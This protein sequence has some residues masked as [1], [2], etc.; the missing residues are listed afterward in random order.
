MHRTRSFIFSSCLLL[1]FLACSHTP[2]AIN[3]DNSILQMRQDYL[4]AHPGGEYN[5]YI[6]RGEVVRGMN[7][8]EVSA[9]WGIPETRRMSKDQTLEYWTFYE[10]D[11]MSGDWM[12]YTFVFEEGALSN[13]QLARHFTKNGELSQWTITDGATA[14]STP[15][16]SSAG[17]GST[18][19]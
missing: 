11:E 14:V 4:L 6:T 19:R 9:S 16:T 17:L 18:R 3:D 1:L 2:R 5:E 7:C 13:W 10:K 8:L 12:R 15:T